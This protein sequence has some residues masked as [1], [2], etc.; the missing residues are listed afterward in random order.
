MKAMIRK[1]K[2]R[3]ADPLN[4]YAKNFGDAEEK[5]NLESI[6]AM[7]FVPA[8]IGTAILTANTMPVDTGSSRASKFRSLARK[9]YGR[10]SCA[11]SHEGP[12]STPSPG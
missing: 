1:S 5:K 3:L 2:F 11:A 10:G 12:E 9:K 7:S 6:L 8:V 4:R